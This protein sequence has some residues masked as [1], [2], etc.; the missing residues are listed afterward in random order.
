MGD[1]EQVTT[2]NTAAV[3]EDAKKEPSITDLI[4]MIDELKKVQ[5]GSDKKVKELSSALTQ[6]EQEKEELKKERMTEKERSAFE[7]DQQRKKN[8]ETEAAL[9]RRE[10]ALERANIIT[11]M[12]I[13]KDL[14]PFVTG[15]DRDDIMSNA[16]NLMQT[17]NDSV[18][19]EVNKRLAQDGGPAPKGGDPPQEPGNIDWP[20]IWAMSPGPEKDAAIEKAFASSGGGLNM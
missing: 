9:L 6:S 7:L 20:K 14:A 3:I 2:D 4:G 8:A 11:E 5:S 12:S 17:F 13:P 18:L 1:A 10:L 19:K 15:K 16:K